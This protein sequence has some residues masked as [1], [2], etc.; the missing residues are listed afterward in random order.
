MKCYETPAHSHQKKFNTALTSSRQKIENAFGFLRG[1]RRILTQNSIQNPE[2][3][4]NVALVCTV[5]HN[6]CQCANCMSDTHW[7]VQ[8][9][10]YVRIGPVP[11]A[12]CPEDNPAGAEVRFAV[13]CF[14]Q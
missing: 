7:D 2:F 11:P 5:L 9:V 3:M 10:D 1:R 8:P 14:L 12:V 4:R 6:I 13:A